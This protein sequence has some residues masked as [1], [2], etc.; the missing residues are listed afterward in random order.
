MGDI[1][2]P[3]FRDFIQAL[4]DA[5]VAYL[6]VGGYAVIL[7]GRQ[8]TTGDMDIWVKP[9]KENFALLM[10]AFREFGLPAVIP[11]SDFLNPEVKDVFSFGRSPVA[12]DIM[13]QV[14]GLAFDECFAQAS[15]FEDEGLSI[16]TININHLLE[17]KKAAGRHKDFDDIEHLQPE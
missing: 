1:F 7:H 17:A 4:N 2:N 13:T 8:R 10:K 11:L 3:D 15:S 5:D 16:R 6:M 12:I 14:K 9:T